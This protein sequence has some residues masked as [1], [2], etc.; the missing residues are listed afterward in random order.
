MIRRERSREDAV[1]F[2]ASHW[3]R[4]KD[5]IKVRGLYDQV[6]KSGEEL[7]DKVVRTQTLDGDPL[8]YAHNAIVS[9]ALQTPAGIDIM[10]PN[11]DGTERCP[12]CYLALACPCGDP[13]CQAKWDGWIDRAADDASAHFASAVKA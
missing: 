5:A 13:T 1:K 12:L 7:V 10:A 8:M 2:C 4:L 11:D 6:A 9:N 3:D